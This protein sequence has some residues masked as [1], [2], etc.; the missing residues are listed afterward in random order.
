M[1][2]QLNTLTEIALID[3]VRGCLAP[4]QANLLACLDWPLKNRSSSVCLT[5]SVQLDPVT[6][7]LHAHT[8]SYHCR[9]SLIQANMSTFK[10]PHDTHPTIDADP[11]VSSGIP[12]LCAPCSKVASSLQALLYRYRLR[13]E[14]AKIEGAIL[15]RHPSRPNVRALVQSSMTRSCPLC[16]RLCNILLN[17][18]MRGLVPGNAELELSLADIEDDGVMG[19]DVAV[20][21]RGNLYYRKFPEG[22]T[23]CVPVPNTIR[24]LSWP[25]PIQ[26]NSNC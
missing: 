16:Y 11:S 26:S 14:L 7:V 18:A 23:M 15:E 17:G 12:N 8:A 5:S 9:V 13:G 3:R 6:V 24:G 22:V 20:N 1:V 19:L 4:L 21:C 25:E 2:R 10:Q